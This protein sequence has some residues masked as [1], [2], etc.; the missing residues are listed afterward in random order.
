MFYYDE[1][2]ESSAKYDLSKLVYYQDGCHDV[3]TSY[4]LAELPNIAR[5]GERSVSVEENRP[6][7][8]SY[9]I[10]GDTQFWWILLAYNNIL[11]FEDLLA[12]DTINYT[13]INELESVY[14]SLMALLTEDLR[15]SSV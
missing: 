12:G 11:S 1:D 8:L 5:L 9:N 4:F 7:L 10:Y 13:S 2:Y 3:L 14:F 15:N 6:D